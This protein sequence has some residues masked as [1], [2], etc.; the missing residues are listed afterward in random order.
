MYSMTLTV[1]QVL[2]LWHV[3]GAVHEHDGMGGVKRV[4]TFDQ[5]WSV[6]D[7]WLDED[8]VATMMH[9]VRQWAE[10]TMRP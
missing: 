1:H 2:D 9:V 7:S 5:D 3:S 6:S 8:P 10:R 4:A